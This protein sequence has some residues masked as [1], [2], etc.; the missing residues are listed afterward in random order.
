MS[1]SVLALQRPDHAGW[2][3]RPRCRTTPPLSKRGRRRVHQ[4]ITA[5]QHFP[6]K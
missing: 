5:V 6:V 1:V 2:V 4:T 3:K